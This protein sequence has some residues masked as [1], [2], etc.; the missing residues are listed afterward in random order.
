MTASPV[1]T[2]RSA[3]ATSQQLR[4]RRAGLRLTWLQLVTGRVPATLAA[5]AACAIGL[6]LALA[7]HWDTYG[8]LQLPLI[9]EA[10]VAAV[11]A[12]TTA[13]PLGEPERATG[14]RLPLLRLATTVAL[15]VIA[16][17]SLAIA[18]TGG[19]LAGGTLD[20]LPNLARLPRIRFL[21][22]A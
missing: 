12:V 18:G 14:L 17:G 6:R 9:F 8:A 3:S 13:S 5:L 10:L 16:A 15:T 11:V 22:P 21:F 4:P 19:H 2:T 20:G 7:W 1:R